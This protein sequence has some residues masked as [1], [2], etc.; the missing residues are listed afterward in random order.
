[1][2]PGFELEFWNLTMVRMKGDV[3]L[4]VRLPSEFS[5]YVET[6]N[7]RLAA[8]H[9]GAVSS[10]RFTREAWRTL[11]DQI[12]EADK[13]FQT[14]DSL[15]GEMGFDHDDPATPAL[16][17]ALGGDSTPSSATKATGA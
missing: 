10:V 16:K 7:G 6:S 4:T 9:P 3:V 1:M 17:A 15:D 14:C 12:G 11:V 5:H 2:A 8:W 13:V